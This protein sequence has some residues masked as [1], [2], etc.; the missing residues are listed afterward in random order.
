MLAAFI[1]FFGCRW[2]GRRVF[3]RMIGD[4]DIDKVRAWFEDYGVIAIILSRPVPMLTEILSCLAGL[5]NVRPMI[6]ALVA[7]LGTLPVCLVF[8]WFGSIEGSGL[9]PAVWIS[10][11]IPAVGWVFTRWIK[12]RTDPPAT[13]SSP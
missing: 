2:G 6:F 11:A 8:S 5:S 9:M 7:F 4:R 10:V 3:A 13:D 1:G 12:R